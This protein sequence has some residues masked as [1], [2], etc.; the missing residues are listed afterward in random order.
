MTIRILT[1]KSDKDKN[2]N[3]NKEGDDKTLCNNSGSSQD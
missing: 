2:K 3:K 1:T